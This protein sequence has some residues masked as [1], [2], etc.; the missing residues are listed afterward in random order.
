[1]STLLRTG[2]NLL[3][4][5]NN[6][7]T[8]K[9]NINYQ[10]TIVPYTFNAIRA[11]ALDIEHDRYYIVNY[12]NNSIT[13]MQKST[14]TWLA[15]ITDTHFVSPWCITL[16]IPNDKYYVGNYTNGVITV[17]NYTTNAYITNIPGRSSMIG[18]FFD[19]PNN[20]YYAI[21]TGLIINIYYFDTNILK[22]SISGI[23]GSSI[24]GYGFDIPNNQYY[25]ACQ[26]GGNDYIYK[27]DYTTNILI[28]KYPNMSYPFGFSIDSINDRYY[29]GT[30]YG[31]IIIYQKSTN[32][33]IKNLG[34]LFIGNGLLIDP[35][36]NVLYNWNGNTLNKLQLLFS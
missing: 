8:S 19:I 24:V 26:A 28:N 12:G 6:I 32:T 16:D 10:N 9:N 15:T 3:K 13:I 17:M 14:D 30:T 33:L 36:T 7:F 11:M 1:M 18:L 25:V 35:S 27:I 31:G 20:Q 4:V 21:T 2:N 29:S 5:G 22:Q 23:V 34:S